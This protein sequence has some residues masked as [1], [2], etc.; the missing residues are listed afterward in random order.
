MGRLANRAAE[1]LTP[2]QRKLVKTKAAQ[3]M[4][5]EWIA[6]TIGRRCPGGLS[7]SA[8]MLIPIAE[9][10]CDEEIYDI[11]YRLLDCSSGKERAQIEKILGLK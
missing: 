2:L 11:L 5:C 3:R 8:M 6:D 9:S 10:L 7:F 1:K 4:T